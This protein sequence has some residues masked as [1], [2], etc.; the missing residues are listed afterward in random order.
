MWIQS[1]TLVVFESKSMCVCSSQIWPKYA[2]GIGNAMNNK[3]QDL[4]DK[5][6][7]I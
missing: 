3:V 6:K 7:S 4:G 1:T 5:S 2:L